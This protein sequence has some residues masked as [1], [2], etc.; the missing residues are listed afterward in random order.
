MPLKRILSRIRKQSLDLDVGDLAQGGDWSPVP[1]TATA[2]PDDTIEWLSAREQPPPIPAKSANPPADDYLQHLSPEERAIVAAQR[3]LQVAPT[4]PGLQLSYH[5]PLQNAP[6]GPVA[7][8]DP[9]L[10]LAP[11]EAEA[12]EVCARKV[13]EK[14]AEAEAES[15]AREARAAEA[16]QKDRSSWID[17]LKSCGEYLSEAELKIIRRQ[18]EPEGT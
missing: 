17:I 6:T 11:D 4:A 2:A 16:A 9:A 7:A 3:Q 18:L 10:P 5:G 1:H 12:A 14:V 13:A 8:L 15:Q